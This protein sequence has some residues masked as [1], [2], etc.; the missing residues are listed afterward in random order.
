MLRKNELDHDFKVVRVANSL[1]YDVTE[2]IR[3]AIAVRRFEPGQRLIERELCDMTGVSRTLV[4]EALRQLESEGLI[5]IQP[6]R[7]PVVRQLT[8]EQARGVYDVRKELEG[9]AASLFASRATEDERKA[10]VKS[11]ARLKTALAKGDQIERLK[12][13]NEFYECLLAGAQ[14][15]ALADTLRMLNSR[16]TFLRATSLQAAGRSQRSITE[17]EVL[18]RALS[19]RD[20]AAA[21]A[22]AEFHV[23]NAAAEAVAQLPER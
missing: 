20:P 21:R 23:T 13:K 19:A 5:V 17:L 12:A 8:A 14:N 1:R 2:S 11:F 10:L 22:A 4:R 15:D 9:L 3:T 7:G 16:V 6:N 18:M